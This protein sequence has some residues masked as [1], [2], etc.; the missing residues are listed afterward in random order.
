MTTPALLRHSAEHLITILK[1]LE[2]WIQIHQYDSVTEMRGA[3]NQEKVTN[4]G[5][6][7]RANYI[8]VLHNYKNLFAAE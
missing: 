2:E 7:E 6:S 8:Q 1:E 3:M 5:A 4:P